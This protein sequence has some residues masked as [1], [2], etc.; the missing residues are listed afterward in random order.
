MRGEQL[1][2]F[3]YLLNKLS[4]VGEDVHAW[5]A[6]FIFGY[7]LIVL[8]IFKLCPPKERDIAP[9]V[10]DELLSY[11]DAPWHIAEDQ[12][13]HDFSELSFEH[14]HKKMVS[15]TRDV[16]RV[17]LPLLDCYPHQIWFEIS[18]IDSYAQSLTVN[19]MTFSMR[20]LLFYLNRNTFHNEVISWPKIVHM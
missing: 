12:V 18:H 1:N 13:N 19:L 10:D 3:S 11:S 2:S 4:E 9:V 17:P 7:F 8:A 6:Y 5:V 15:I 20:K 14:W 16:S